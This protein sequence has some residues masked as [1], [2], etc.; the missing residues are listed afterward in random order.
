VLGHLGRMVFIKSLLLFDVEP[1][2][3][4]RIEKPAPV[5]VLKSKSKTSRC[6]GAC[7]LTI[8]FAR[9]KAALMP[10][11]SMVWYCF[12]ASTVMRCDCRTSRDGDADARRGA[13][14]RA[15]RLECVRCIVVACVN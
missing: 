5:V 13:T 15:N 14:T 12:V 11:P 2:P 8:R 4:R 3:L 9:W 1:M 7:N 10:K 6:F